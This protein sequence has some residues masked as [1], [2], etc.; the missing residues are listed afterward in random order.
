[1]CNHKRDRPM[2]QTNINGLY[3]L[4]YSSPRIKTIHTTMQHTTN[5]TPVMVPTSTI[6][7]IKISQIDPKQKS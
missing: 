5:L 4:I 7:C 3:I 1:M 2:Y 6:S